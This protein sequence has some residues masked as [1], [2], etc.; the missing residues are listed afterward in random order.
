MGIEHSV[1]SLILCN[2][3][4]NESASL[5]SNQ[6]NPFSFFLNLHAVVCGIFASLEVTHTFLSI[7]P[8]DLFDM[9][10]I[11]KQ[12]TSEASMGNTTVALKAWEEGRGWWVN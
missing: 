3:V 9:F 6:K 7:P 1:R 12:S 10:D 5:H 11:T 4:T 2:I 8:P